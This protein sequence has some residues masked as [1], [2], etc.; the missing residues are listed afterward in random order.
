MY[1]YMMRAERYNAGIV[2]FGGGGAGASHGGPG[3]V[4]IGWQ[5]SRGWSKG[6]ERFSAICI[7][8]A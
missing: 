8:T 3:G 4:T 1:L 7:D 2:L 6:M 5:P